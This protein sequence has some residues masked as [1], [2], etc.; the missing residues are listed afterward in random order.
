MPVAAPK[1]MLFVEKFRSDKDAFV[2]LGGVQGLYLDWKVASKRKTFVH[3]TKSGGKWVLTKLGSPPEMN[4]IQA[5]AAASRVAESVFNGDNEAPGFAATVEHYVRKVIAPGRRSIDTPLI[6]YGY[7]KSAPFADTPITKIERRTLTAWIEKKADTA[8]SAARDCLMIWKAALQTAVERGIIDRNPMLGVRSKALGIP[9]QKGRERVMT[10]DEIR[11]LW[12]EAESGNVYGRICIFILC[13][14]TRIGETLAAKKEWVKDDVLHLPPDV[15]KNG[16]EFDI[17][18]TQTARYQIVNRMD[19]GRLWPK[20]T[21]TVIQRYLQR[22]LKVT[23]TPHDIRRTAATR[24]AIIGV[25]PH[26]V[27]AALNH[28]LSLGSV[29]A[30]YNRHNYADERREALERLEQHLLEIVSV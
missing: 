3:R 11:L 12:K 29:A 23:F 27:D 21:I 2:A 20:A 17:F 5:R 4:L 1:T 16:K 13:C 7:A 14:A 30:I 28:R 15:T 25:P 9:E 19:T 24:M 10:D 18:L 8:P 6:Y 26:V 22:T